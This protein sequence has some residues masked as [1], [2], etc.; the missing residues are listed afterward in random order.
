[1]EN[2]ENKETII[3][4]VT[5]TKGKFEDLGFGTKVCTIAVAGAVRQLAD[6]NLYYLGL[7]A[8]LLFGKKAGLKTMGAI[9]GVGAIYNAAKYAI[10]DWDKKD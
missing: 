5:D 9:V 4:E 3:E 2:V 6:K 1:M 10:G 7:G 8:G